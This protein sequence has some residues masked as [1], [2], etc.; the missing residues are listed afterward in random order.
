MI[1]LTLDEVARLTAG[2]RRG[3]DVLIDG[4][5]VTDSR[6]AAAG[7]LY[8]A[9]IGEY[10]DGHDFAPAAAAAG[11]VATLGLRPIDGMP[12]VVVPDVQLAF[13][14][15]ARGVLDRCRGL[16]VV[17]ITGSS[18]KTSTKDMLGQLLQ[19]AGETVAP[20]GSL[21]S[22]VG[23][24]LTVCRITPT[25]RFLVAEMGA[26]GVGHIAYLTGIAPPRIGIVLNVGMAHVGEFGS[27]AAIATAKAELVQALPADGLAILNADDPVVSAMASVTAA[28]V[29]RVGAATDADVR[30]TDVR[31]D[32]FGRASFTVTRAGRTDLE[33]R[34]GL[35]GAH[36][37]GNALAVVACADELGVPDE[38]IVS[39][40]AAAKPISRW[41]MEVHT[42]PSGVTL[43]NDAYNA[44]PDSMA[45]AL[46]AL[47]QMGAGRRTVA[48][49]GEMREL[50]EQSAAAHSG[51][52]RLA[53][54]LGIDALIVVGPGAAGIAAG[55]GKCVDSKGVDGVDT[56]DDVDSAYLLLRDSM[57]EGDVVLFKSS[58]DSGLRYLGDRIARDSGAEISTPAAVA[59]D[60]TA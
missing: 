29:I 42:L 13:G 21:N 22:E 43:I 54:E 1:P 20:I 44:N 17:G 49:L 40:L 4:P 3:D 52:G 58:R 57:R 34:L 23:V 41:R 36:Q 26:S 38:T 28:R 33:V 59:E 25:T 39:G 19:R 51:V 47:A 48:V 45:A 18:G 7:S 6:E 11:A 8:V 53:A 31:L 27:V 37:V 16:A 12:T 9:R 46:R 60:S 14:L 5:V 35:Y 50:G 55:A 15:L 2:S 10:A 32:E 30:A 24:P 56:V